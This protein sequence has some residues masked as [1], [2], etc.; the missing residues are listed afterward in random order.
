MAKDKRQELY[1][2][3]RESSRD[4]VILEEMIRLG[5]WP[6]GGDLPEDPAQEIRRRGELERRLRELNAKYRA[7]QDPEE[8]ARLARQRRM[9][10]SRRR[11]Q[12][13]KQRRIEEREARREAWQRRKQSEITYLGEGVSGGL[14]P[15]AGDHEKL[16]GQGL[17]E[18][19]DAA[20]LAAA[21]EITVSDLR[22]LAYS[23]RVSTVT[24]YRRFALPKRTG[25]LRQISAP[26]PRL[27]RVQEWILE[28]VLER[29]EVHPDAHGFRR[30]RSI[31]SNALPHVGKDVVVN[32]DL[33][34]FFPTITY[35]RVK[36]LF[37]KLGYAES[38]ATI[39]GLIC[40]EPDASEVEMDG[41]TYYVARAERFLPQGAPT[42]PA[43][44]N[45]ICRGLDARLS[46]LASE[47]GFTYTR[48]ADD[49]TFSASGEA[50]GRCGRLLR[51]LAYVV[52]DE[53]FELH[54]D[55]TRVLRSG[56][57]QEVT[58]LVV[59]EQV[60]VPRPVLRRF[61]AM[62]HQIEK[63]GPAGKRWGRSPNVLESI[64]G[65]ANFVAMVDPEKGVALKDR[66]SVI[67][68]RHPDVATPRLQRPRWQPPAPS[69]TT[70][71]STPG[72]PSPSS[73]KPGPRKKRPWWKFWG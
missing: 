10:E 34:D 25:G 8:Y 33:K 65:F 2:R 72:A 36:G 27:K 53:G 44:T 6:R 19:S 35:R 24:H 54:P 16:R 46:H 45:I 22:F 56:R 64:A 29:V 20:G 66:V 73:P 23:R 69:E 14:R 39:F 4:E 12:E 15:E 21:L 17:P 60:S 67:L 49:L 37:R 43:I 32:A 5:F 57:R 18:L 48:Y 28:N 51:R 50:A 47:L 62:L 42:S 31:V 41:R 55:K 1:D 71:A 61:R 63:D 58:G 38:L 68:D 70:S 11:R 30:G 7:T 40:S 9:A 13:T 26:M 59:N 3:I 52:R